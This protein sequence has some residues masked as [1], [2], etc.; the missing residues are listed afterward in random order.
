MTAT[1]EYV[2]DSSA[3]IEYFDGSEKGKTLKPIIETQRLST[4]SI[5][6]A[7]IVN[8]LMRKGM[9]YHDEVQ[10][11]EGRS[12]VLLP[13]PGLCIRAGQLKTEHRR[14]RPKFGLIDAIHLATAEQQKAVLLTTDNDFSGISNVRVF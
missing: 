1:S 12:M 11:I 7:E 13:G 14:K 2:V 4:S 6:I 3:W 5:A 9:P 10:F 8:A